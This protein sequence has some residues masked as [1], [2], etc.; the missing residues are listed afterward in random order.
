[1]NDARL[2]SRLWLALAVMCIG[3]FAIGGWGAYQ[4]RNSMIND[5]RVDLKNVVSAAY[6]VVEHYQALARSGKMPLEDAQLSA[7]EDLR[8][9]RYDSSGGYLIVVDPHAKILMHGAR[10]ELDGKDMSG[11]TDP[12]GHHTFVESLQLAHS[13]GEG[14]RELL[15]PKPG[16]DQVE[17]KV[18][19][20]KLYKPWDWTIISGVFMDE[21]NSAFY[22]LLAQYLVTS[23]LLCVVIS[24]LMILIARNIRAILGGEPVYAAGVVT[25]IADG[26]LNL[27]VSTRPGDTGSMLAAL[28][29]MQQS[30]VHAIGQIR[31]GAGEI[32]QAA[33]EIAAGNANLSSRTEQQ[34][35][36][37]SETASSMEELTATVQQNADNARQASQLARNASETAERGGSVVG[38]VVE[39][40]Q[41]ISTSSSKI[42]DIISVIEGIA[43]Q[44]NIL[45]L[46]AAV[47]AARAGEEGRGFAVVA[48]EVRTLAQRSAAAAKEI[49]SLIEESVGKIE[50]GSQLVTRAGTTIADVV[51]AVRQVNDIMGEISAASEEQS[52]GI[53]QV[54]Q[55]IANMDETTQRNAVLVEQASASADVLMAQTAKLEQA[56]AVF[57]LN[58]QHVQHARVP[59]APRRT[60]PA[61][62]KRELERQPAAAG[63]AHPR[64]DL[65]APRKPAAV[66]APRSKSAATRPAAPAAK[67]SAAAPKFAPTTAL[68]APPKSAGNA[69]QN[70]GWETF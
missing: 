62:V 17:P 60:A 13:V 35:A 63:K 5:S 33:H 29:R 65:A 36:S 3:I 67:P 52:S 11:Y 25:R 31:D 4:A 19:Y 47:E 66:A 38:E 58:E 20:I 41:E 34:A 23:A 45:A 42:V 14:Y 8:A 37:I 61:P 7:L 28:Q 1:M 51:V 46:N 49:K 40:M 53:G 12:E 39:T 32:T 57:K 55:A 26:E 70:E 56:I 21:V 27:A 16:T 64:A 50:T 24:A 30:L 10:S 43:F 2:S 69:D 44:T 48:G 54:N 9:M 15:F 68:A 22:S 6:G 18:N 59:D